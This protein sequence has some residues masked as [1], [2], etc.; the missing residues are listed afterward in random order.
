MPPPG[1]IRQQ[2]LTLER[3]HLMFDPSMV[4]YRPVVDH[5]INQGEIA[6]LNALIAGAKALKAQYKDFDGLINA[7]EIASRKA[8]ST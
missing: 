7:A 8:Q 3:L 4:Y 1:K 5:I 2:Y 6:E